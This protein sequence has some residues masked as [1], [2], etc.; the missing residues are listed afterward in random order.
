MTNPGAHWT[1]KGLGAD[2]PFQEQEDKLS[3]FGL[4]I[5]DWTGDATF[6]KDDGTEVPGG[7][8]EVHFA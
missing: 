3:L 1:L 7:R 6:I 8:G 4:F 5:G 2:G